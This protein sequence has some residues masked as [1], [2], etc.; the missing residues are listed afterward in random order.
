M[1]GN[2][3][4][5]FVNIGVSNEK[6]AIIIQITNPETTV[7]ELKTAI[8][9]K[10]GYEVIRLIFGGQQMKDDQKLSGYHGLGDGSTVFMVAR[11]HGGSHRT[12]HPSIP[13]S[14]GPCSIMSDTYDELECVVTPCGHVIHPD[15]LIRF[16]HDEVYKKHKWEIKCFSYGCEEKCSMELLVKCGATQDELNLISKGMSA[17]YCQSNAAT[18]D[19]RICPGCHCMC[20]RMDTTQNIARCAFCTRNK[21]NPYDFCWL[22]SLPWTKGHRCS[23]NWG[24][25]ILAKC[26]ETVIN[27]I[28]CPGVRACPKCGTLIEHIADC[29]HMRCPNCKQEFC[30]VCLC[31]KTTSWPCGS[32]LKP[33]KPAPRQTAFAAPR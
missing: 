29:K 20:E 8:V 30:F 27:R 12:V 14:K 33:C 6:K 16:C 25:D 7:K 18:A 21:G 10:S 4:N 11:V 15:S 1:S 17:N 9:N 13:R 22:C 26:D 23:K 32:H 31:L 3:W 19:T 2:T 5:I 28:T 24:F